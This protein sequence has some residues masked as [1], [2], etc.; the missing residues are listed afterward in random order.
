MKFDPV[1]GIF[2]ALGIAMILGA[3]YSAW[4]T[5]QFQADAEE[6]D[7][8]VIALSPVSDADGTLYAPVV[9]F[10]ASSGR[11]IEFTDAL[12]SRPA[13]HSVG[14]TVRVAYDPEQPD[15]TARVAGTLGLYFGPMVLLF[16][17]VVFTALGS[18][19]GGIPLWDMART[20]LSTSGSHVGSFGGRWQNEDPATSGITRIEIDSKWPI[21]QIKAW[22]KCRPVDCEWGMPESY[23]NSFVASGELRA[24]WRTNFSHRMQHMT[25]LPDGRMQVE[26]HTHFTDNS[27]RADYDR[28]EVFLR[29]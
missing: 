19:G 4:R 14:Q 6:T 27:G 26:T 3:A 21:V 28:T 15:T 2:F 7:G 11:Q 17:G 29:Q 8:K 9:R 16:I 13:R 18:K 5:R 23:N 25:L 1:F 22:G 20:V 12:S 24:T 10:H